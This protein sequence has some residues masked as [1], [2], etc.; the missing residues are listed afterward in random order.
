MAVHSLP[1][2]CLLRPCAQ[3]GGSAQLLYPAAVPRCQVGSVPP[4]CSVPSMLLPGLPRAETHP[5]TTESWG[6]QNQE[7]SWFP[8]GLL[9]Q[10]PAVGPAKP[11][12]PTGPWGVPMECSG[13]KQLGKVTTPLDSSKRESPAW[14]DSPAGG[15]TLSLDAVP[16]RG[17]QE[18]F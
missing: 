5:G 1:P 2:P 3:Q 16:A 7:H 18:H 11:Q 15:P 13:H 10:Q 6:Q 4:Q 17:T 8:E 12:H 9:G 14:P